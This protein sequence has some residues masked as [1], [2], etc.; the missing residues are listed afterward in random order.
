MDQ[1]Y[2]SIKDLL[3]DDALVTHVVTCQGP[4]HIVNIGSGCRSLVVVD[5]H[6]EPELTLRRLRERLRLI[7]PHWP[8]FPEAVGV[9]TGDFNICEPE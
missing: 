8:P 3:L 5:A 9:I 1:P 4:D 7:T 6:F 2:A